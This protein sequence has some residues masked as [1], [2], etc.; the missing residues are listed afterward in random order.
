MMGRFA[1][2]LALA[3][4]GLTVAAAAFGRALHNAVRL[5]PVEQIE[6]TAQPVAAAPLPASEPAVSAQAVQLAVENDPFREEREPSS[7]RY[8]LPGD[9]PIRSAS[10]R[11]E[12][13]IEPP[14][15][16]VLGTVQIGDVGYAVIETEDNGRRLISVGETMNG[17]RLTAVDGDKAVLGM[18]GA[19]FELS[20]PEPEMHPEP[21]RQQR[22]GRNNNNNNNDDDN[23]NNRRRGGG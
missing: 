3:A 4:I 22:R 9:A 16:R 13:D 12:P 19:S 1:R 2:S 10:A 5:E 23:N 21:E 18:A 15:F 17:F 6:E 8:R 7:A 11:T 20:V 14:E